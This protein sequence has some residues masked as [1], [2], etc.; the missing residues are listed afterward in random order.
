MQ[1]DRVEDY[2]GQLCPMPIV[3]MARVI[4]KMEAGQILEVWADDEGAHA[5]VP[6]WCAKTG[7]EFLGEEDAG[8]YFRYYVKKTA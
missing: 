8:E 6:A 7:N 3:N 2:T 1:A 4:K 5:D